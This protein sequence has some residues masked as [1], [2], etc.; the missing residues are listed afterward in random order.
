MRRWGSPQKKRGRW[1]AVYTPFKGST[2]RVWEPVYPNTRTRAEEILATRHAELASGTWEDPARRLTF[3]S[4]A[5]E[6]FR[7]MEGSWKEQTREGNR[8]RLEAH[9]LPALDDVD[10][11]Q[12][13][14][15]LLQRF[16][17]D[18]NLAPRT[19]RL[20]VQTLR[21]ILKWGHRHG[22]IRVLPDL[23]I[24][25][26]ALVRDRVEPLTH[27][28]VRRVVAK[29]HEWAPLFLW[30]V[31]TGMRQGEILAAKWQYLNVEEGT[32]SVEQSLQRNRTYT[33]PK[34]G[35][36]GSVWVPEGLLRIMEVQ[37]QQVAALQLSAKKWT[38]HGLMFPSRR[39]DP[40]HHSTVIRNWRQACDLAK[41][42][43]RKFHALRH[44]CASLL[45]DQ[46]ET[47]VT[48]SRQLRHSDPSI[49]LK[50]YSHM[51]P[52]R[53]REALAKLDAAIGV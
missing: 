46:G 4:L 28:E 22:R 30:A 2:R 52:E 20:V 45:I 51:M 15:P 53:G 26:P 5:G 17:N 21:Q 39:G 18:L 36:V 10:V 41:V 19:V 12:I 48:V 32:Y 3:G 40:M 29:A 8:S 42:P 31:Y 44:T 33:T 6:W 27:D 24:K 1:H 49:T 43:R 37:R 35:E 50:V 16:A 13:D 23:S 11:R 25:F 9:I 47:I 7:T 38:D 34:G 14:G